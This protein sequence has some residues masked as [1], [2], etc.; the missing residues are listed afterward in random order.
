MHFL[1]GTISWRGVIGNFSAYLCILIKVNT[2]DPGL[3]FTYLNALHEN[4]V[5]VLDDRLKLILICGVDAH[6]HCHFHYFSLLSTWRYKPRWDYAILRTCKWVRG[7]QKSWFRWIWHRWCH[8]Y[9]PEL[10]FC[11]SHA[12]AHFGRERALLFLLLLQK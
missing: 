2:D 6:R 12:H 9:E 8:E 10:Y 3:L 7:C 11:G 1:I 4:Q 5:Q